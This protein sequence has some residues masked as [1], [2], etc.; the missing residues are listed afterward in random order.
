MWCSTSIAIIKSLR[1]RRACKGGIE[2]WLARRSLEID[3]Q[4]VTD[5]KAPRYSWPRF[6]A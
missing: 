6:H 2:Q 5:E 4:V 1:G 3:P